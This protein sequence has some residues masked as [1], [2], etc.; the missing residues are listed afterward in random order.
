MKNYSISAIILIAISIVSAFGQQTEAERVRQEREK[1]N[2]QRRNEE[3][4]ARIRR[5]AE[6]QRR[7][8]EDWSTNSSTLERARKTREYK[9]LSAA[10]IKSIR[11]ALSPSLEDK[12][13]YKTFLEQPNTGLFRLM[14]NFGCSEK[15]TV[16]ADERCLKSAYIGE[17]FSFRTKD[18]SGKD[19]FDITF[20]DG[21]LISRGFFSQGILTTLG[22]MPL[23]DVSIDNNG[24]KF[25]ANFQP[26]KTLE[27]VRE[28]AKQINA[29]INFDNYQY[30]KSIT[31]MP[32]TSYALRVIAYR[33]EVKNADGKRP[34]TKED[35]R[36]MQINDDERKDL[37]VA[38]RIVRTDD[39]GSL[40]ILWKQLRESKAPKIVV[41]KK[42]Q[43]N[44][45]TN[46]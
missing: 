19:W 33:S 30:A 18:Y 17:Y 5:A 20:K 6:E 2:Q 8:F 21:N 22:N 24:I 26:A 4:Q 32:E 14:P 10:E 1:I 23:E 13:R 9:S 11:N 38:F 46:N 31:A 28:Q 27:K 29:G 45:G 12:T 34:V 39:D 41:D 7:A 36:A 43:L 15:Y 16:S 25:L 3:V 44:D 37:I 40:I 35:L 42:E